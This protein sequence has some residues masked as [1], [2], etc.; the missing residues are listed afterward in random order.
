MANTDV[1]II[2]SGLSGLSSACFLASE[3]FQVV[4]FEKN[5]EP[6]GYATTFKNSDGTITFERSLSSI[7]G[8]NPNGPVRKNLELLGVI[9]GLSFVSPAYLYRAVYPQHDLKIPHSDIN[10]YIQTFSEIFPAEKEGLTSFVNEIIA[11]Y[12]EYDQL[13]KNHFKDIFTNITHYR[14][15][16]KYSKWT[17][18]QFLD[19]FL[20]N[21]KLKTLVASQWGYL[22]MPPSLLPAIS[23]I[24]FW[25]EYVYYGSHFPV[26]GCGSIVH[27]LIKKIQ[28]NGG[29][30]HLNTKIKKILIENGKAVGVQSEDGSIVTS[31]IVIANANPFIVIN[32]L[33]GISHFP[34]P[35]VKMINSLKTSLS[36]VV[37]YLGLKRPVYELYEIDAFEMVISNSYDIEGMYHNCQNG[38]FDNVEVKLTLYDN[39]P[40]LNE[41]EYGRI[42]VDIYSGMDKWLALGKRDSE[43]F[44][45]QLYANIMK[46]LDPY[47]PG[48]NNHVIFK[49]IATPLDHRRYT[50]NKNGAI[51]GFEQN[52]HQAPKLRNLSS[53]PIENLYC[54]SV[55]TFPG[56]GYSGAIWSGYFC[57]K[58]NALAQ[59][60]DPHGMRFSKMEQRKN[61]IK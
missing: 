27:S 46:R 40:Q 31:R 48:L 6:G 52:I 7:G 29:M 51:Y 8:L 15:L 28:D 50:L 17:L 57:V 35:Y 44:K 61:A 26:L 60:M 10:R 47:M 20:Q 34:D 3:G 58:E 18:R 11:T 2:G 22:G 1:V 41:T 5:S 24:T 56:G 9:D 54:S 49:Q 4:M 53:T 37:I 33:V 30:I 36:N 13:Q 38:D 23:F 43:T 14:S 39:L 55:W 19:H 42:T 59:R 45:E 12:Y 16:I 32:K 25:M 21:D